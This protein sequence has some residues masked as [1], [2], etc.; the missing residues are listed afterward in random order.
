MKKPFFITIDTEGDS[1]WDNPSVVTT[2]NAKSLVRFQLLCDKYGFKPVYLTDYE[3]AMDDF[4]VD[5]ARES[6]AKESCEVGLHIHA[7]NS[8]PF[9]TDLDFGESQ[10]FLSEFPYEEMIGKIT[11]LLDLIEDRIGVRPSSHRAGR[12]GLSPLYAKALC[13]CGI[14]VDCS[15][16]PY[17]DWSRTVGYNASGPDYSS[18]RNAA[19]YLSSDNLCRSGDLPL[20]EVPVSIAPRTRLGKTFS[21]PFSSFNVPSVVNR[22]LYQNVWLRPTKGNL[23]DL[24]ALVDYADKNH[25][26]FLEFILHSSEFAAG[27]NPT[28]L[29]Q[30]DVE[31]LFEDLEVLFKRISESHCGMTLSEYGVLFH[32]LD[33][34]A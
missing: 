12:W 5:F 22:L 2:E 11:A 7:W 26:P 17:K 31:G 10:P 3:M 27:K 28:F 21:E 9:D 4:F 33:I 1:L 24:L 34:E 20:L 8:P 19:Y 14:L 6:L 23:G 16:T 13:E 30:D 32:E 18:A 15:V 25:W 29:T